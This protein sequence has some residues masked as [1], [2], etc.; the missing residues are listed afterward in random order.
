MIE[1]EETICDICGWFYATHEEECDNIT[2]DVCDSPHCTDEMEECR[3]VDDS[4]GSLTT[5]RGM[6][7]G[8]TQGTL[9]HA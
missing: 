6:E 2:Y 4:R 9:Y 3:E 5:E 7:N 8:S 1:T